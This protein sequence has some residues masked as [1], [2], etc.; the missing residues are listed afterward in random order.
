MFDVSKII[1][2]NYQYKDT[3]LKVSKWEAKASEIGLQEW[4][5]LKTWVESMRSQVG[6]ITRDISK[7]GLER[8]ELTERDKWVKQKFGFL[9][10]HIARIHS[11]SGVNVSFSFRVQKNFNGSNSDGL[12]ICLTKTRSYFI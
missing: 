1:A 7:S 5:P 4:R 10:P 11:R 2:G 6:R 9:G 8:K 3:A 12:T